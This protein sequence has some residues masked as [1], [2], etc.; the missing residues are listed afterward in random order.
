MNE[1]T[2]PGAGSSGEQQL[3]ATDTAMPADGPK[4]APAAVNLLNQAVRGA[5]DTIDRLADRAEPA[6]QRLGEQAAAAEHALHAKT[7]QLRDTRDQWV[8]S[9]RTT[10]REKPLVSVAAAIALGALIA[11][12]TR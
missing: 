2:H 1:T 4:A 12:I 3:A 7:A 11:R 8:D 5:H 9:V 10:V 6:A